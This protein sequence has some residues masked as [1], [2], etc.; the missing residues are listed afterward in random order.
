[1]QAPITEMLPPAEPQAGGRVVLYVNPEH[2][3][4]LNREDLLRLPAILA[5]LPGS[6]SRQHGR[7]TWWR[8]QPEWHGGAGLVVRQY[9]HGGLFAFLGGK[10]FLSAGRM[11]NE[12]ATAI[13]A[14]RRGVPTS[15]PVA[16][17][18]ERTRGPFVIA[19]YVS[20]RIADTVNLLDLAEGRSADGI[21]TGPRRRLAEAAA[22][23]IAAM[24]DAGIYHSDL[25]LTNVLVRDAFGRPEVF[26]IDFDKAKLMGHLSLEQRMANLMRL[27]RSTVKWAASRRAAHTADRLR[28]LRAYLGRYPQW[29]RQWQQIARRYASSHLRHYAFREAD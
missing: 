14:R 2:A 8:W 22:S 28:F 7:P 24:H 13:Y 25:N 26:V 27:D 9:A 1:M 11:R 4:R 3:G 5:A 19:H 18:I 10:L 17:R 6:S 20:E 15:A 16:L 23:A 12:F 21:A 29:A